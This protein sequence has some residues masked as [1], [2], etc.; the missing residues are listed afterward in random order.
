MKRLIT[1]GDSWTAGHAVETE[2]EFKE[3]ANPTDG[4]GFIVDLRRSNSW[5]RWL[6][7]KLGYL[8]VNRGFSGSGNHD[9]R[10]EIKIL[11][12]ENLL[13]DDDLIIVMFSYPHRYRYRQPENDPITIFN[14][15]E[16]LLKNHKHFYFNSFYATFRDEF[17]FDTSKLP[18]SFINPNTTV[19]Q[20]LKD[21]EVKHD[22][23]VWEYDSR[24]VFND[25]KAFWE[26]DYHPN[27]LGY[28]LIAD[29]IYEKIK[30]RI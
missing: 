19:S 25:E 30:D 4:K 8:F 13:H 23:S 3:V 26:G 14:E 16:E 28:K 20:V 27:L 18:D 5:P 11:I 15:I 1:F 6:S 9:M 24:S 22:V 17:E 29:H 10:D 12:E 2:I 21:Y 7:D